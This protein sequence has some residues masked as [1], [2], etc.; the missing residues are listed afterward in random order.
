MTAQSGRLVHALGRIV[1]D[2]SRADAL[3]AYLQDWGREHR[4]S[5]AIAECYP[6]VGPACW[7]RSLLAL[8]V[9][10]SQIHLEDSGWSE[11]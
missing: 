8:G 9:P 10:G 4:R 1:S 2:V 7:P 6:H 3:R 5:G 11:P